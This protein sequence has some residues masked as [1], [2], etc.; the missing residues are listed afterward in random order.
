MLYI[1]NE[2]FFF[3]KKIGKYQQDKNLLEQ[4]PPELREFFE[5]KNQDGKP[6]LFN[7]SPFLILKKFY[8]LLRNLHQRH[9]LKNSFIQK[10]QE[11]FQSDLIINQ[12]NKNIQDT[13]SL[14]QDKLIDILKIILLIGLCFAFY[15]WII[16]SSN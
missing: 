16:L 11:K 2:L 3:M 14:K 5:D 15:Y 9:F 1:S 12:K 4:L 8:Q 6:D 7:E 13:F 10:N